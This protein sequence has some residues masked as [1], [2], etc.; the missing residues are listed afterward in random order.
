MLVTEPDLQKAGE[1]LIQ[2]A[3]D[4]D[5]PDNITV[6]LARFD[7]DGAQA[8]RPR[9]R[10]QLRRLRP[11]QRSRPGA[12]GDFDDSSVGRETVEERLPTEL[13]DGRGRRPDQDRRRDEPAVRGEAAARRRRRPPARGARSLLAL[14]FIGAGRRGGGRD[15]RHE[16]RARPGRRASDARVTA[17]L[18]VLRM[19]SRCP[20]CAVEIE[21]GARFCGAC[22]QTDH[23]DR[24]R[25][26]AAAA[27][28]PEARRRPPRDHGVAAA[29]SRGHP[30]RLTAR[31]ARVAGHRRSERGRPR[32]GGHDDRPV[33]QGRGRRSAARDGAA[34][35]VARRA[36]APVAALGAVRAR[37]R[38]ARGAAAGEPDR[39]DAQPPLPRRGQDRRR[40]LR[41]GL[42]RQADR[43][44]ARGGAQD[45]PPAQRRRTRRSSRASAARPRPA[46]SCATRTPSPPT[47]S[48]RPRTGSSTWRWSSCAGGACTSSRRPTG[49]SRS[50]GCWRSSIRSRRRWPRRTRNGIVHRDMKP[51]N[52]FIET[53]RR[54]GPRQGARL[55]HRQDDLGREGRSR[56]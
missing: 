48:T 44:R 7:G 27:T 12:D 4:R 1:A 6:V 32:V 47:T 25:Q 28:S 3:L 13:L 15:L 19:P 30:V 35:A 38:A 37:R 2:K 26:R 18:R 31:R 33:R 23:G 40:R 21:E 10:R 17:P 20:H 53:A 14:F 43:D 34:A 36:P 9:G 42:P 29:T 45:P 8:G 5:G 52:V 51:E 56:R 46:R 39:P 22:G 55:R 11:G 50:S 16:V 41:R 24:R 54:R 49:R